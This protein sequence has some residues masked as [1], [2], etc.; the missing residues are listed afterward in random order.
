MQLRP[1]DDRMKKRRRSFAFSVLFVS[2][3]RRD[4]F[5]RCLSSA[6]MPVLEGGKGTRKAGRDEERRRRILSLF[7]L[8]LGRKRA[9][10]SG[11][12]PRRDQRI[13][14]SEQRHKRRGLIFEKRCRERVE[15]DPF[16]ISVA[17]SSDFFLVFEKKK[18][19]LDDDS[20]L[21]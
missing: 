1:N 3:S 2:I 9:Q 5:Y 17:S 7:S 8:F 11:G 12:R 15:F 4:A 21:P 6:I 14:P 10:L 18:N 19:S 16:L 20:L 13:T